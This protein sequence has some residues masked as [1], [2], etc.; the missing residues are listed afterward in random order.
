MSYRGHS[1]GVALPLFRDAVDVFYSP[2]RLDKISMMIWNNFIFIIEKIIQIVFTFLYV[3]KYFSKMLMIL[4]WS[5][6]SHGAHCGVTISHST[7]C[8]CCVRDYHISF[9]LFALSVLPC[10]RCV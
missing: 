10:L 9:R 2:N 8:G 1:F 3:S 7:F 6:A 4:L 5:Y